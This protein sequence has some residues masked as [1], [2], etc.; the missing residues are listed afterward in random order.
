MKSR[1]KKIVRK[2]TFLFIHCIFLVF[3]SKQIEKHIFRIFFHNSEENFFFKIIFHFLD[4]IVKFIQK[5]IHILVPFNT[6]TNYTKKKKIQIC[7]Q[8]KR[9]FRIEIF[10]YFFSM[11]PFWITL[12][13]CSFLFFCLFGLM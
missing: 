11:F 12:C 3:E 2:S 6:H 1:E 9:I 7:A 13:M 4:T 5:W 10:I 8:F